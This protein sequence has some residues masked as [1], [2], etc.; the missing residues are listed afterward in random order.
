MI[1][2]DNETDIDLLYYQA[3][4]NTIVDL[5]DAAGDAPL[6]IGVHGDWGA[7]KSSVLRML[8]AA[9]AGDDDTL[10]IRFNGWLF[11]GFEDTKAV[12][13]ETI[14]DQLMRER[15]LSK[16]AMDKAGEVLKR[17]NWMKVARKMGGLAF[18]AATGLPDVDQLKGI[19][20]TAKGFVGRAEELTGDDIEGFITKAEGYL[21]ESEP[22]SLPTQI[23]E[24]RE[25]F[26]TLLEEAKVE[27]LIVVVDDLDRCLPETAIETLEAIRLFLF[28]PGAAFV[29]AADEP[30]I[31]YA[32]KKHFPDLPLS[33]GPATYARNYLEKLIQVPFRL[34]PLGYVETRTYV[35]LLMSELALGDQ[36]SA[37]QKLKEL[38]KDVLR[39][40]WAGDGFERER[41]E[42]A[43]GTIPASVENSIQLADQIAPILTDGAHGNPRQIKR[44]LNTMSLR[45][46]I[47]KQRGIADEI[48]IPVLSKLM[49]VERFDTDLYEQ[50]GREANVDG[51]SQTLDRLESL[52]REDADPKEA[53][54]G[55]TK[56]T[57][58]RKLA[59]KSETI[60]DDAEGTTGPSKWAR[61]WADLHPRLGEYDLRPYLFI[62]RDR[63]AVFSATAGLPQMEAW[64]ERLCGQQLE[65]RAVASEIGKLPTV[66]AERYLNAVLARVRSSESFASRPPGIYGLIELCKV[67]PTFQMPVVSLLDNLPVNKLGPWIAAGWVEAFS[68][69]EAQQ[70]FK[71][72][73]QSWAIQDEN[74]PLK[75]ASDTMLKRLG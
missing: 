3:V 12:L 8:E 22:Q 59:P 21:K 45:L 41:I 27:R 75:L 20:S 57:P 17:V 36:D 25:N 66:E 2:P 68:E 1:I 62:S 44:F 64:V 31:E 55:K 43:L 26:E 5:L 34:P 63:K 18:T 61:Q 28:V 39:R 58:K 10:C 50:I 54:S 19:L 4:A 48:N 38:A 40:P 14:I 13:I 69:G 6:T 42:K 9:F 30:M 24:F 49:L 65:A 33:S 23:H 74:K 56:R 47:A 29:I 11:Q 15:T 70:R 51:R 37:F 67:H 72:I 53:G 52:V 73:C 71:A 35:T 60:K 32:V 46:A 7:G 16:K